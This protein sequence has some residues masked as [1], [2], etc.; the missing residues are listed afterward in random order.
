MQFLAVCLVLSIGIT[1]G[2]SQAQTATCVCGSASIC[3]H[4]ARCELFQQCQPLAEGGYMTIVQQ[5]PEQQYFDATR[6]IC[7]FAY[8]VN[9][10]SNCQGRNTVKDFHSC[11]GFYD[12]LNNK[13]T[14]IQYCQPGYSY[15]DDT[16]SCVLDSDCPRINNNQR[17]DVSFRQSTTPGEYEQRVGNIWIKRNCGPNQEFNMTLCTCLGSSNI[18]PTPVP[19]MSI[20][21]PLTNSIATSGSYYFID[22]K[23][24]VISNN[25][26][27]VFNQT[28]SMIIPALS[29]NDIRDD[30]RVSLRFQSNKMG[31]V[32]LI[33]NDI[34]GQQGSFK[35]FYVYNQQ[36]LNNAVSIVAEFRIN[37]GGSIQTV[38]LSGS[39]NW[40]V[41]NTVTVRKTFTGITLYINDVEVDSQM[42]QGKLPVTRCPA[43]IGA[44]NEALS[45]EGYVQDVVISK[46]NP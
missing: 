21:L 44:D 37:N 2:N 11:N 40:N 41:W 39:A 43:A 8:N 27:A 18:N 31:K 13:P 46:C 7:D 1:L 38:S 10:E 23:H 22:H 9:C 12:C 19:C 24:V 45:F 15:S 35:V 5:C 30:F 34:C 17:C 6:G 4:P 3:A 14:N 29:Y 28:S 20:N 26:Y 33:S 42:V 32:A 25:Q 16:Q 36:Q